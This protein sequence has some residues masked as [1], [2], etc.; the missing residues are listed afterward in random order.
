MSQKRIAVVGGGI[1]GCMTAHR[2]LE[3]DPTCQITLID[4][5]LVG[6]G[7]SRFSAGVHFPVGR[8]SR[9]RKMSIESADYYSR[10]VWRDNEL[11]IYPVDFLVA[12][13]SKDA[14]EVTQRCIGLEDYPAAKRM[15]IK[16][17][18]IPE[19]FDV[20]RMPGCQV[21][22]VSAL[23]QML[24]QRIRNRITILESVSVDS[25]KE[26]R[27]SVQIELS[28]GVNLQVDRAVLCPGP[29]AND[30]VFRSYTDA[31]SIRTKK[32]VAL[33]LDGS[34]DIAVPILFP[35]D[36]VFIVPF[37]YRGHWL[38]SYTCEDWDVCPEDD[39]GCV[40]T[41]AEMAEARH[42]LDRYAGPLG[43]DV[44]AGRVF[45]DAYSPNGE[46]IVAPVGASGNL[47]FAGAANGSGYRLA[48]AIAI[49]AARAAF[50]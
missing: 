20:W 4:K 35:I 28:S 5:S 40:L 26:G 3:V 16:G 45:Y 6:S 15:D 30:G 43:R 50:N 31:L 46:P 13:A 33:H 44:R 2:L 9:V 21:A 14:L 18:S 42:W 22:N 8:S 37:A 12:A 23:V 24:A 10:L 49:E 36:D 17:L 11:P 32:V 27:D 34:V 19:G 39:R 41:T 7:A 1:V 29:W 47:I 48:P 38:F 25:L